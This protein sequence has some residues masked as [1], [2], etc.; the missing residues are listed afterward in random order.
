MST[1]QTLLLGAI[2]G[3]TIFLGLPMG[4]MRGLS[5]KLKAFFTATAT[6]IL[7][8]LF[9]D[10]LSEAIDPVQ[11]ALQAK[12]WGRFAGVSSIALAGF[13]AGL[14]SLVY[15]DTWMKKRQRKA[16]LGPGAA[17]VAEFSRT[18]KPGLSAAQWLSV[19][20]ATGIGLHN[21]SEGLAIGQSAAQD[22]KSLAL[23]LVIGFGL[24][25]A[26]EGFGIVGPLSGEAELPSWRFLGL[27]G[28]I[29]GAAT[30]YPLVTTRALARPFTYELADGA[31]KGAVVSVPLG[32]SRRRGVVVELVDEAPA[33]IEPVP[34]DSVL[35]ELPPVLVDLALWVADYYGSTPGRALELIAPVKRKRRKEQA[36]PGERQALTDK[37]E[38]P[39]LTSEQRAA[40]EPITTALDTGGGHF[41]LYG[42]TGSGKTEVYLQ[43]CA[44]ALERGKTAIVLVPEIALT[45]P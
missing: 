23:V 8:F 31:A 3:L 24:H 44:A 22:L 35:D 17:S 19:F 9:W 11:G 14:M 4:R 28:L 16:M 41:L 27:M 42:E 21:F 39:E 26:T 45:P 1:A 6:G 33:G 38:P 25:N 20:I 32:R 7:L 34:I 13:V 2:A 40:L 29:G 18:H 12:T 30:F 5:P 10:V 43:A 37:A 36:P 15:Y